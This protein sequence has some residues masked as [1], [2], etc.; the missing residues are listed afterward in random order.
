MTKMDQ[1]TNRIDEAQPDSQT[2][3]A[4]QQ[5]KFLSTREAAK[6]LC[7]SIATVQKMAD[8]GK[9]DTWTTAGGHRRICADSVHAFLAAN[10]QNKTAPVPDEHLSVLIAEDEPTQCEIYEASINSWKLP[11]RLKIVP[12][13]FAALIEASRNAPDVMV[14][15]LM[16]PGMSGFELIRRIRSEPSFRQM[17]IMVVTG[18]SQREIEAGGELPTDVLVIEKPIS[19]EILYGFMRARLVAKFRSQLS[20]R[21]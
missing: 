11:I 20:G 13:G 19:F 8:N 16:M 5:K 7:L 10:K 17:D 9:L 3:S 15:D 6:L 1:I 21:I 12:D 4:P 2:D 14:I 18:L